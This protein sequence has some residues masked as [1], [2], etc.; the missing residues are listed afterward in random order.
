MYLVIPDD[1]CPEHDVTT[2]MYVSGI[3]F[4]YMNISAIHDEMCHLR[5]F[6][7]GKKLFNYGWT[8]LLQRKISNP[9][10][11]KNFIQINFSKNP[12]CPSPLLQNYFLNTHFLRNKFGD[13]GIREINSEIRVFEKSIWRNGYLRNQFGD[14]GIW[15]INLE[16]R[17]FEKWIWTNGIFGGVNLEIF[18]LRN[19]I[20]VLFLENWDTTLIIINIQKPAS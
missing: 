14:T 10:S 11:P 3:L 15:E 8:P 19:G 1:V 5:Y 9:V 7:D 12:I 13:T 4:F 2:A 16:K 17:V 6:W 18:F 20:E